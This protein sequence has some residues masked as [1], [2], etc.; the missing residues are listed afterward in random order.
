[1]NIT[2]AISILSSIIA[3]FLAHFFATNRM[4]KMDLSTF[5]LAAYTDFL[6]AASRLAVSR[7]LGNTE[8]EINDLAMLNDSKN[9]ILVCGDRSILEALIKFWELGATLEGERE[10]LAFNNFLQLIRESLGHKKYDVIDLNLTATLFKL[11][12][13]KYSFK[14]GNRDKNHS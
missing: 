4:R 5:Q 3:A 12:P 7:R 13:S 11:E 8:N 2:I 14:K 1:M 9:R 6:G 10:L